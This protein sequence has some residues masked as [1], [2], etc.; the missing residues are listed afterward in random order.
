M[1]TLGGQRYVYAVSETV[2]VKPTAVEILE[3]T[4]DRKE[5]LLTS[6]YPEYSARE[7][8]VVISQLLKVYPFEIEK[9]F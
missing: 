9:P 1:E 8:I 6:C 4:F 2:I 7:R 5:L 3:G